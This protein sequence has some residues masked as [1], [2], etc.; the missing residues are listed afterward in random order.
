MLGNT[1]DLAPVSED[2]GRSDMTTHQFVLRIVRYLALCWSLCIAGG[3]AMTVAL[4]HSTMTPQNAFYSGL[5]FALIP[6]IVA[7]VLVVIYFFF[8][9]S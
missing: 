4:L 7:A 3:V 6:L 9:P 8:G 5:A 1:K 2:A